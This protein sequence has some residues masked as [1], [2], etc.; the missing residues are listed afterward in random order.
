MNVSPISTSSCIILYCAMAYVNH[1]KA[2]VPILGCCH[3]HAGGYLLDNTG[4]SKSV[5]VPDF[6]I[7]IIRYTETF[8]STCIRVYAEG[9]LSAFGQMCRR[10]TYEHIYGKECFINGELC[11]RPK[12]WNITNV[13]LHHSHLL[14]KVTDAVRYFTSGPMSTYFVQYIFYIRS[15]SFIINSCLNY[16]YTVF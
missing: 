8:W 4:W 16:L 1:L 12:I 11:L 14:L 13:N 10:S 2:V 3:W 9:E 5:C 7:V 6:C 15:L